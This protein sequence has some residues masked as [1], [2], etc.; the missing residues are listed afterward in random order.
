MIMTPLLTCSAA[1]LAALR[2]R[3]ASDLFAMESKIA[4][5]LTEQQERAEALAAR[6]QVRA[7]ADASVLIRFRRSARQPGLHGA[8]LFAM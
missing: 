5:T 7:E 8:C 6:A 1:E 2:A 3:A 4:S